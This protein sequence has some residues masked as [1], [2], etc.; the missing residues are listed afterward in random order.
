MI[1][2][3]RSC[4][5]L[6]TVVLSTK[7]PSIDRY[8]FSDC[9]ELTDFYIY[10][11]EVPSSFNSI[12]ENSY[13]EYATLHVPEGSV[14]DYKE[15]EPW[16]YF[17]KIVPLTDEELGIEKTETEKEAISDYYLPNGQKVAKPSKGINIVRMSDGQIKK[18]II[19]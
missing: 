2:K 7:N 18:V 15:K 11:V 12:F 9:K 14:N 6:A 4:E 10:A 16:K 5:K 13:I 1:C 19:K 17:G 8:A 3:Y